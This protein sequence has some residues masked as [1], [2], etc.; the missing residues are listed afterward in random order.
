MKNYAR[1]ESTFCYSPVTDY[2]AFTVGFV[3]ANRGSLSITL[4]ESCPDERINDS[5]RIQNKSVP[6]LD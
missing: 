6:Y 4:V 2:G 1:K 3:K 5:E